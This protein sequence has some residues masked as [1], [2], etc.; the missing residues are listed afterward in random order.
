MRID[1]ISESHPTLNATKEKATKKNKK[2]KQK[3]RKKTSDQRNTKK[4]GQKQETPLKKK[5][6]NVCGGSPPQFSG[7]RTVKE[8]K[9]PR[10]ALATQK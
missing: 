1:R 3:N 2:E 4:K 7:Q 10:K 6:K 5:S 9:T 8:K